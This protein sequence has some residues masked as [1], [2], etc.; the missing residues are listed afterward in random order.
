MGEKYSLEKAQEEAS[1][2]EKK[3]KSGKASDYAEAE[4]MIDKENIDNEKYEELYEEWEGMHQEFSRRFQEYCREKGLD[5]NMT[6]VKV[7]VEASDFYSDNPDIKELKETLAQKISQDLPYYPEAFTLGDKGQG[8]DY[9][10]HAALVKDFIIE[11]LSK[12]E[13][14]EPGL[15]NVIKYL[16][17]SSKGDFSFRR[18]EKALNAWRQFEELPE[19][20]R[21]VIESLFRTIDLLCHSGMLHVIFQRT[22]TSKEKFTEDEIVSLS[23]LPGEELYRAIR[24][25]SEIASYIY[26][27]NIEHKGGKDFEGRERWKDSTGIEILDRKLEELRSLS[28]DSYD[29]G[30]I[31]RGHGDL[32][33]PIITRNP[34]YL[35]FVLNKYREEAGL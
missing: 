5:F 7:F 19:E 1:R 23:S 6:D 3:I 4:I 16:M 26:A 22:N 33:Y 14:I 21:M 24:A 18:V 15:K 25:Y 9:N 10:A 32:T 27:K 28:S 11:L 2:L 12:K 35:R 20:K 30:R 13:L 31:R 34:D 17:Y 8:L 29:L